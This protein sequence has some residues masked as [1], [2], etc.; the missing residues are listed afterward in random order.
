MN[1]QATME[2]Y[3]QN[4][5]VDVLIVGAG[6]NGIGT[7]R[8]L[9]L[10]GVD[11]LLV[12]KGDFCSGASA[13]SSRMAHGGIRYLEHGEFR[14]VRES[15][16][17]RNRLL[18]NAPH[19]VEPVSITIP[20]FSWHS[21]ILNA[22]LKFLG[23]LQRPS[24]RGALVIKIGLVLYDWFTRNNRMTPTHRFLSRGKALKRYTNLNPNIVCAATYYDT[25]MPQAERIGVELVLDAEAE[26]SDAHALNYLSLVDATTD[27][28]MLRDDISGTILEIR[29]RL[30]INASGAWIDFVNRAMKQD[31]HF[32]GG[33]K[34]SHIIVD[35]AELSRMLDGHAIYFENTDGRLCI[36]MPLFD[37]VMIGATDIRIDDPDQAVCSDEEIDYMLDLSKHVL[38]GI[39]LDRSQLVFS[40]SG[41]R[42]LQSTNIEYEGLI[43]RD[44]SI[45]VI[46][47]QPEGGISFPV[48]SL[49][50]GKWT[51]YRALGEQVTEKA[52]AFLR[53]TRTVS[54]REL[55]IGG[56][57]GY[58]P[59]LVERDAW[60]ARVQ[61][62]TGLPRDRLVTLFE[63]YGTRSAPMAEYIAAAPDEP[64]HHQPRYSRR[65]IMFI[66]Q[67]E[68]VVH[69]D[70]VI[71]RRSLLGLLGQV[72]GDV[73]HQV[74]EAVGS[75]QNWS[76]D[77]IWQEL[78]RA[79]DILQR[80][81][82]VPAG[83]L[84]LEAHG[85]RV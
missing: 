1:R 71:L 66:A 77:R 27:T 46:R 79:V 16:T 35:H 4:P 42:P 80:W 38:P 60:L 11:V 64:L 68:K 67:Q 25:L 8:D 58:P 14:L 22:P 39:T 18:K 13:A 78:E 15:L 12:D 28:V 51:T 29:P 49:V 19:A 32:I 65:E 23:L 83:H 20:I 63:R 85:Q 10:Q 62:M 24:E 41:V 81:H 6:I 73:L 74:A 9:A 17:E 43:S 44:H 37:K 70:D 47:S 52:L 48:Y 31:T 57:R 69:L 55:A 26:S 56:G 21:G 76:D 53:R 61:S 34:G 40:F 72:D 30:V 84:Q 45:P 75:A 59:G 82:G 3:R 54:T 33:T 2:R 5:A 7:F 36:F 50:G